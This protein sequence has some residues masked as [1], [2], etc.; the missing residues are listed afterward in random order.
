VAILDFFKKPRDEILHTLQKIFPY[1]Y[2]NS[3]QSLKKSVLHFHLKCDFLL[4]S[5]PSA[6]HSAANSEL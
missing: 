5:L 6:A 1:T 2:I 4:T 3:F